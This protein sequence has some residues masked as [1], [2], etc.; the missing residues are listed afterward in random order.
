MAWS[1]IASLRGGAESGL[2]SPTAL[3]RSRRV[4]PCPCPTAAQFLSPLGNT[5]MPAAVIRRAARS[6]LALSIF[7]GDQF[8]FAFRG[9]RRMP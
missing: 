8:D 9:L 4:A 2:G 3:T 1:R 6:F 5:A 7:D